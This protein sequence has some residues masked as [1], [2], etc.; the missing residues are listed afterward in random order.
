VK[1]SAIFD[2]YSLPQTLPANPAAQWHGAAQ[3]VWHAVC[4]Q[5]RGKRRPRNR[6]RRE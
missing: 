1:E 6:N 5:W 4:C 2:P 3:N